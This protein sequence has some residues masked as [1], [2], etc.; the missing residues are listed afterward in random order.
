MTQQQVLQNMLSEIG[1]SLTDE[2]VTAV[3]EAVELAKSDNISYAKFLEFKEKYKPKRQKQDGISVK[4]CE[5]INFHDYR[6]K[7]LDTSSSH[8]NL[9]NHYN[10]NQ[11]E[12]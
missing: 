3:Q 4:D 9:A 7:I 6:Q 5:Y 12:R 2:Q 1:I 8:S 11:P 10:E